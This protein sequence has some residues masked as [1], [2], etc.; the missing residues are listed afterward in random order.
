MGAMREVRVEKPPTGGRRYWG[1][2]TNVST[3][4]S[5]SM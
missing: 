4:M 1:S 3:A 5:G 2:S